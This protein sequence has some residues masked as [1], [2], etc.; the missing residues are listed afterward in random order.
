M[1]PPPTPEIRFTQERF[2]H[3]VSN[4]KRSTCKVHLQHIDTFYGCAVCGVSICLEL[5]FLR[6]HTLKDYYFNDEDLE[7][8]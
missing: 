4:D 5:C 6:Y 7:G 2:H 1:Q 3:L 8:P